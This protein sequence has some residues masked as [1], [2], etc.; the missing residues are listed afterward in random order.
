MKCALGLTPYG[1]G[2]GGRLSYGSVPD[3]GGNYLSFTYIRPEP[4]P[5]GISYIVEAS[6]DLK[7][8]SATGLVQISSTLNAG[9]RTVTL[10]DS[11]PMAPL[12]PRFMRLRV[13][14]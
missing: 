13:T 11:V 10:R 5:A 7:T 9:L 12:T 6:P 2:N 1:N 4:A 14:K 3:T 8:W